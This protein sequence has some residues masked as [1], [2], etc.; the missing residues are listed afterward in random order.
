VGGEDKEAG[1][2]K[3]GRLFKGGAFGSEEEA[4]ETRVQKTTELVQQ[5]MDIGVDVELEIV[6][7]AKHEMEK[8]NVAVLPFMEKQMKRYWM[9]EA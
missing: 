9:D 7:G 6:A 1:A 4:S 8:V 5:W 2:G 3:L